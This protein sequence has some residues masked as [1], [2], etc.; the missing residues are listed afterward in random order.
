[1]RFWKRGFL[2]LRRKRGK[3]LVL[4]GLLFVVNTLLL[5]SLV[6]LQTAE[7][8]G[9]R[10]REKTGSKVLLQTG[11]GEGGIS[12]ELLVRIGALPE[13]S[14]LNRTAE[15]RALPSGL[16]PITGS[17]SKEEDNRTVTLR[18]MDDTEADGLFAEEKYRLLEGVP[19]DRT[20]R[21]GIL[22]NS[23]L[24]EANGLSVGD[25]LSFETEGG[26]KASGRI[27]GLFFSGMERRQDDSVH[28]AHRI[29]N[30]LFV[31][32]ALFEELF[33]KQ[34]YSSVS[35]YSLRPERLEELYG[36]IG[37]IAGEG[38]KLSASDTLFE[39]LEA[40]LQQVVSITA[41][42]LVLTLVTAAVVVSLI[43]C[44]WMRTR[45]REFAVLISLGGSRW[46][47]LL[48]TFSEAAC[49]FV[50][51]VFGA[52]CFTGLFAGGILQGM[53]GSGELAALAG[54]HVEGRHL[55]ALFLLG[56]ALV[57]GSAGI[58][59]FPVLKHNPREILSRM[60]E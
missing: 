24:A 52:A 49:L 17:G 59:A 55:A 50:L 51:S 4:F 39:R 20:V 29:E 7:E 27:I 33:G 12:E 6:I 40:P 9:A 25:E 36:K 21:K 35:V 56:G 15:H 53:F 1:M 2:Y 60:E 38:L 28:S 43:L 11:D 42:L 46:E 13:V 48:Q 3:S 32:F 45:Q 14:A 31:D 23:L 18:A 8:A 30:Q 16:V 44:M 41:A 47:L 37:E 19:I 22:V 26:G 10:L 34:G 54:A 58:S 5:L 57:L